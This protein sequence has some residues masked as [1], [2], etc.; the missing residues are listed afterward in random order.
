MPLTLRTRRGVQKTYDGCA[1]CVREHFEHLPGLLK[2]YPLDVALAY[3]FAQVELAHNTALYTGVVKLHRAHHDLARRAIDAHHLTR[4]G[5]LG[6]FKV[7]FGESLPD[8][9]RKHLESAEDI[10]DR[11]MHGKATFD[12]QKRQAI[13]DVLAYAEGLNAHMSSTAGIRP[14]GDLRGFKGRL[15]SHDKATTRWILKGMGFNL[16]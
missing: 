7:V 13:A 14:F 2:D 4:E 6:M 10:R 15:K 3:V 11:V 1:T 5:F 9:V 16:S 8:R 12:T